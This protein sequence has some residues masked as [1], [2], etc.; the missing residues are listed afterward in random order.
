MLFSFVVFPSPLKRGLGE[1]LIP[2][3]IIQNLHPFEIHNEASLNKLKI[4]TF[5]WTICSWIGIPSQIFPVHQ[6]MCFNSK[7]EYP[8]IFETIATGSHHEQLET[9]P[10]I[11]KWIRG[12][13]S[14]F[15][16][17]QIRIVGGGV[18]TG[19]T[20]HVSHWMTCCT[21]PGWLWWGRI[22]WNEDWQ[23]K[24]KYSEKTCPSATLSTTN[25]T[26]QT[27]AAAVG[28]QWLTAWVMARPTVA[29]RCSAVN[30]KAFLWKSRP[31]CRDLQEF[32]FWASWSQ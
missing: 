9:N 29:N 17:Q 18:Q 14:S 5:F 32:L 16:N 1:Y 26:C 27:R 30:K 28:S 12:A 3:F 24:P 2:K 25:P 8:D 20:R 19:S 15:S 21:C 31:H 7:R 10:Y 22:W 23:G 13:D 11:I 4:I 6:R